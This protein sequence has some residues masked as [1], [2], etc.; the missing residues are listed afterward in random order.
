VSARLLSAKSVGGPAF[1]LR[2]CDAFPAFGTESV[3]FSCLGVGGWLP[4][5]V[6]AH[7]GEQVSHLTE[8]VNFFFEGFQERF[9]FHALIV[10]QTL[11]V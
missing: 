11:Q 6:C 3:F 9:V 2:I 5:G 8:P 7:T 1:T 10:G 4:V